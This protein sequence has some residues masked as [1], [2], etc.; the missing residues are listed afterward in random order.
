MYL[1]AAALAAAE[2]D[3]FIVA[4]V[5]PVPKVEL[6][7]GQLVLPGPVAA[8]EFL[9]RLRSYAGDRAGHIEIGTVP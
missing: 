7:P 5:P 3:G 4:S 9:T 8:K 2:A 1:S 6:P